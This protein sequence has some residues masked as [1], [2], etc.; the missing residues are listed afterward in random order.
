MDTVGQ[1]L[2]P[3]ILTTQDGVTHAIWITNTV[4]SSDDRKAR[5]HYTQ[6]GNDVP[7]RVVPLLTLGHESADQLTG[8]VD[9]DDQIGLMWRD[10]EQNM[11]YFSYAA[12]EDVLLPALWSEPEVAVG[13]D[14][15]VSHPALSLGTR[16]DV[17]L[18][19]AVPLNGDPFIASGESG[20]VTLG[21]LMFISEYAEFAPLKEQLKL[22]PNS[23]VLLIN[24]ERNTDPDYFRRV[25]WEG[26]ESVPEKY[27][28]A[29]ASNAP[30]R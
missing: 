1:I 19:Y 9:A 30:A 29:H 12:A 28:F 7:S 27:R 11:H 20:A 15:L 18:V 2:D 3:V 22:G 16:G 4:D 5:I 13:S 21:A 8:I 23:Q 10:P 24:S 25:V 26:V 17:N 6:I 14:V